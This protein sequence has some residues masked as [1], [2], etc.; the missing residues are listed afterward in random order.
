MGNAAG[1]RTEP[2]HFRTSALTYIAMRMARVSLVFVPTGN[3][4]ST[5]QTHHAADR[6]PV[7]AVQTGGDCWP[8]CVRRQH[9]ARRPDD[10]NRRSSR[11]GCAGLPRHPQPQTQLAPYPMWAFLHYAFQSVCLICRTEGEG[12]E[13]RVG[14]QGDTNSTSTREHKTRKRRPRVLLPLQHLHCDH[15]WTRVHDAAAA[16]LHVCTRVNQTICM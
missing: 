6:A 13:T 3:A 9:H 8:S 14:G 12:A 10:H 15:S 7:G 4:G 16:P 11:W 5:P 2:S 1:R